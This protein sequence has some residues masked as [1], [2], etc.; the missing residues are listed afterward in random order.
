MVEHKKV[1]LLENKGAIFD[2]EMIEHGYKDGIEIEKG[3]VLNEDYLNKNFQQIGDMLSI[4]SA[5]P[6]I[7]LDLIT[8]AD[9]NF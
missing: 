5:Y 3:V 2:N 4:F 9:S 1:K 8:P 7:F 6:D